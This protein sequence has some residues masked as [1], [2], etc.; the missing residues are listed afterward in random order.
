MAIEDLRGD[1]AAKNE[2]LEKI[3]AR[4]A[5]VTGSERVELRDLIRS[6]KKELDDL[7]TFFQ[8]VVPE[9]SDTSE[10]M[11][12]SQVPEEVRT[13]ED[14][15]SW[16]ADN[17]DDANEVLGAYSA[18]KDLASHEQTLKPWQRELLGRKISTSSFN[19]FGD[20][21]QITGALAKGWLR[22]DGQ[23]IDAIAQELSENGLEVTEQDIVDFMLTHPSNHV[24]QVSDTMRSL[25]SK[26]SE[27]AT[28]EMG[29]PVGGPE[30]NTGKLYLQ[31]KEANQ[32]LDELTQEQKQDAR[33]AITADMEASDQERATDYYEMLDDYLKQYD[34]FRS[35]LAAEDADDAII[36]MM[37]ES[38]PEL[39]H[40]GF[41]ADELDDIYSQIENNNGTEG[42]AEDSRENQ[43]PLSGE[44]VEQHEESG[45]P[46]VV[47]TENSEGEEQ[48]NGVIPN[49]QLENIDTQKLLNT[50]QSTVSDLPSSSIQENGNN[51]LNSV[52]NSVLSQSDNLNINENDEVSESIPQ[53]EH[54][55][56][57]EV[58]GEQKESAYQLRRG[59]K[60]AP[61]DASES[62][63]S[64]GS[65]QEVK[66]IGIGPFG[67]I[68]NQFKNKAKE[69][70]D[71]C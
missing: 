71:F 65:Q 1:V 64:R 56:L 68:Y 10:S 9:Q 67:A 53:G 20:R 26:F 32:K 40:G 42:Q 38:N 60:E 46:E 5:K 54:G 11:E 66:P 44:E 3:N 24:S 34:Q 13:D 25:S 28:K 4:L 33:N 41:T 49:E 18:A 21:N 2:E 48:N 45:A 47:A 61:R 51:T 30:S 57:P 29:I 14:Y 31:F 27:I 22:K 37:E 70:I 52:D 17:S 35:E 62:E 63:G 19:R 59:I 69:A 23:E 6:K 58:S 15:I 12:T 7:K 43:S 55:T 50:E 36:Q 8:S 16:V 39:Y